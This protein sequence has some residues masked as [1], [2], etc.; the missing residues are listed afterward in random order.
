MQPGQ[1]AIEEVHPY[2]HNNVYLCFL[3]GTDVLFQIFIFRKY[4]DIISNHDEWDV[5]SP[6]LLLV[7][8]DFIH[9]AYINDYGEI[10]ESQVM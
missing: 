7:D 4:D 2:P 10:V 5:F 8:E 6:Y 9:Y 3:S 1:L